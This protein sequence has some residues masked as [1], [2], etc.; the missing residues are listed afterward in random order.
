MGLVGNIRARWNASPDTPVLHWEQAWWSR[1]RLLERS[2]QAAGFLQAQDLG[3]G[4][5]VGLQAHRGP[6]F[7]AVFL[8]ALGSGVTVLLL[9]GAYT[10]REVGFLAE[11]ADARLVIAQPA[12]LDA[13]RA[14]EPCALLSAD[15]LAQRLDAARGAPIDGDPQGPTISL[16]AVGALGY[17]SGT[18]GRPKGAVIRHRN[19]QGTV[20]SLHTAW[21]WSTADVLVHALPLFHIHGLFVAML[22]SLWAGAR[23]VLL[24]RFSASAVSRSIQE[25]QGTVFMGVP[26]FY[27]RLLAQPEPPELPSMR[28]WT[29]GSAPLPAPVWESFRD[30]FGCEILER[31]G[32]TEVGIVLSNPLKADRVPGT[33]GFALPGVHAFVVDRDSGVPLPDG[34]V[35]ELRISSPGLITH[36]LGLPEKTAE[37]ISVDTTGRRWM[38]TGDLACRR[39]DGRFSI[40]GRMGD[41]VISGGLNVYPRE[42][43]TV[44]LDVPG[45]DEVAVVGVPDPDWG[46]R[47]VALVVADGPVDAAELLR[48]ARSHLA[49]FK[50]P[51]EVRFADAL[52]RNS[53]GKV[54]KHRIRTA[55]PMP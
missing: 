23:T 15:D 11:D 19:I 54:Q 8:G 37:S 9:N 14:A 25:H 41:M 36:Y 2:R 12:V 5:V 30:R 21:G 17:T 32:M 26:T 22:G 51:K 20:E 34:E 45:V 44:L 3:P 47:V 46:E 4:D 43:E 31:Y 55:W 40:V 48:H 52:P 39:A 38:R 53:M 7:L 33:V 6:D 49:G 35:G 50:V 10:P 28:L 1:A 24:P 29:S 13:L 27:H 16:E 18:T 42:I